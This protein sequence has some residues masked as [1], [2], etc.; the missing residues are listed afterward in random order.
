MTK[1]PISGLVE[2]AQDVKPYHTKIIEILVDYI[3]GETMN[4]DV[5]DTHEIMACLQFD[6]AI[7]DRV[8]VWDEDRQKY[9][10]TD[11][12]EYKNDSMYC[13]DG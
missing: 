2:F 12:G 11:I 3:Y 7:Q 4:V 5:K 9:M 6:T 8:P 1:D 13:P 10:C